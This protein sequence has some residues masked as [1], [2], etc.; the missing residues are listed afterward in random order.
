LSSSG[1]QEITAL[2]LPRS[3]DSEHKLARRG[4][5]G[6]LSRALSPNQP[7]AVKRSAQDMSVPSTLSPVCHASNSSCVEATDN[8]SGHGKCYKKFG[9]G[10]AGA[11]DSCYACKCEKTKVEKSDGT[12]EIIHWGGS[13]C[14]KRDISSPFFLIA[15]VSVL[16]VAMVSSAIGMLFSV[17]QQELPSVIGAGVGGTKTPM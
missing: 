1:K 3:N 4:V 10:N 13:A 11:G 7:K 15:G 6:M 16:A 17:G 14:Q 2:L 8:C 12:T 9:S 5:S